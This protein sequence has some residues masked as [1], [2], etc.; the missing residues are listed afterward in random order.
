MFNPDFTRIIESDFQSYFTHNLEESFNLTSATDSR[1]KSNLGIWKQGFRD[2]VFV[3]QLHGAEHLQ[4]NRWLRYIKS[5]NDLLRNAAHQGFWGISAYTTPKI[6]KSL[7]ASLHIDSPED[8]AF[9]IERIKLATEEFRRVFGFSSQTF[10]P[11]NYTWFEDIEKIL[12]KSRVISFQSGSVQNIVDDFGSIRKVRAHTGMH[13]ASGIG[14]TIRNVDFE[15]SD[16]RSRN[17]VSTALKQIETAFLWK[18]PAIISSHR[19]NYV[20]ANDPAN[21]KRSI[22]ALSELLR[23]IVKRWPDARFLSSVQLAEQIFGSNR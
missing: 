17:P 13:K 8:K 11:P 15:P 10:I 19:M 4:V 5:G 12:L 9:A 22:E 20:S 7:Q 14:L 16:F 6:N 3:P 21:G 2:G 23:Q 1:Y 18:K